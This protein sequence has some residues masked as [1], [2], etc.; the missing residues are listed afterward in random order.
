MKERVSLPKGRFEDPQGP[1]TGSNRVL[2]SGTYSCPAG[3][4]LP[5]AAR[6]AHSPDGNGGF[7]VVVEVK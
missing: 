2:R 3:K 4:F 1:A 6:F 5:S 7:R